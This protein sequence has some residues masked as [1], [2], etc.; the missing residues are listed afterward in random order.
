MASQS[1]A[2]GADKRTSSTMVG[3][4]AHNF[5]EKRTKPSR[6]ISEVS[7]PRSGGSIFSRL[8]DALTRS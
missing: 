6:T 2:V 3:V 1:F 8:G 4:D 7:E 5:S